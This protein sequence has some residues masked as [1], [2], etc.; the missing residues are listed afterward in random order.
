MCFLSFD[1][2]VIWYI[3]VISIFFFVFVSPFVYL[4]R[5]TTFMPCREDDGRW[6]KLTRD[7]GRSLADWL[8]LPLWLLCDSEWG[9]PRW[10]V[11]CRG[12]SRRWRRQA[13]TAAQTTDKWFAR[14]ARG[15]SYRC[16]C[17]FRL[18]SDVPGGPP[19]TTSIHY[20]HLLSG[21]LVT[22]EFYVPFFHSLP[23]FVSWL[24]RHLSGKYKR[25]L[26]ISSDFFFTTYSFNGSCSTVSPKAF[27]RTLITQ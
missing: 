2:W 14:V 6:V 11:V 1:V 16:V 19:R 23:L 25:R 8:A 10:V 9:M 5:A 7:V 17:L 20:S 24:H 4:A 18:C 15:K 27:G 13:A 26:C 21:G 22:R 12:C 3:F